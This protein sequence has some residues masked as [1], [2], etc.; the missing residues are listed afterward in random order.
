MKRHSPQDVTI[1]HS[2][3]IW[4]RLWWLVRFLCET[5]F[6]TSAAVQ[7]VMMQ[8][9][10]FLTIIRRATSSVLHFS[11]SQI[12]DFLLDIFLNFYLDFLF[13]FWGRN[14][15]WCSLWSERCSWS[16]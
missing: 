3:V 16:L 1:L 4:F 6:N 5:P 12:P 2:L 13:C 9:E 15:Y 10:G 11:I 8:M 14:E 7:I